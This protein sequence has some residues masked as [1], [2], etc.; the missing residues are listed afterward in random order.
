MITHNK[1]ISLSPI[2]FVRCAARTPADVPPEG[3]PAS[4]WV[5][6]LLAA[7]VGGLEVGM[8]IYVIGWFDQADSATLLG[9]PGTTQERGVF[10]IRSSSRPNQLGLTLT[11][12]ERIDGSVIDVQW[13]DY[14]DGTPI[15]DIKRYNARW[16]CIF[17]TPRDNRTYFERLVDRRSLAI[18]LARPARNFHGEACP[19]VARVGEIGATLVQEHNVFLGDPSLSAQIVGNG[20]LIDAWQGMTGASFGNGRLTVDFQPYRQDGEI[21]ARLDS[22][23]WRIE[24]TQERFVIEREE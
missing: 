12:I 21:E 11:Q 5:N 17:G 7:A 4:L 1:A 3:L 19:W 10:S 6:S 20:H 23:R 13:L 9:S 2:G 24:V 15:L 8:H 18:V 22:A 16:E 14:A